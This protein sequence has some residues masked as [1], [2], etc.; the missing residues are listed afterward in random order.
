VLRALIAWQQ[1][2]LVAVER[3][4]IDKVGSYLEHLD[5]AKVLL[6]FDERLAATLAARVEE[7]V[8]RSGFTCASTPLPSGERAKSLD[9]V[10][11]L[12]RKMLEHGV[13][14]DSAIVAVGGGA[15]LDAVGFAASTFMRGCKL[16]YVPTTLLAQA[17]AAIGGKTAID[18][19]GK[20]VVGTFYHPNVVVVDPE[21]VL[22]MPR[23]EARSGLAEIAK[24]AV[25]EGQG[26]FEFLERNAS[27]LLDDTR[28]LE[29][30]VRRSIAV[31]L[32]VVAE[33]FFE[34]KGKREVLNLGHTVG[35]AVEEA[36]SYSVPHGYAVAM[37]LVAEAKVSE[38]LVGTPR[39]DV[40]RVEGLVAKLGLPTRLCVE[41]AKLLPHMLHDKKFLRGKPRLPLVARIGDVVVKELEWGDLARALQE[42]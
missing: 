17:D 15:L 38:K 25:I 31:K 29:E 36:T 40:E 30:A 21:V 11:K 16:V 8:R 32:S 6:A 14:R 1:E 7:S 42:L 4:S 9:E 28:L 13:T 3:G 20:N 41:P 19:G 35:H 18:F 39:E 37:G 23:E 34:R 22:A 33:D 2:V 27:E 26:F 12:W 10:A 24:H 5:P